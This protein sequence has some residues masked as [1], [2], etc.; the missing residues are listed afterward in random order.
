MLDNSPA[1][2]HK[3]DRRFVHR[4]DEGADVNDNAGL[5]LQFPRR[6]TS[7][8]SSFSMAPPIVNQK[9]S[10][11]RSGSM[12]CS[13]STLLSPRTGSTRAVSR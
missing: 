7:G 6:R 11:G 10:A 4:T 8:L 2:P 3:L 9:G 12:P 13:I 5:F 1:G